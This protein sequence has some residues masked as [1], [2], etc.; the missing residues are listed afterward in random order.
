MIL[1]H[2]LVGPASQGN[3]AGRCTFPGFYQQFLQPTLDGGDAAA[4]AALA[5]LTNWFRVAATLAGAAPGA[6]VTN[7]DPVEPA[8][9]FERGSLNR[10]VTENADR[11]MARLGGG[12]APLIGP[13]FAA[14]IARLTRR[15]QDT[16]DATLAFHRDVNTKTFDDSTDRPWLSAS[17]VC[18]TSRPKPA[19]PRFTTLW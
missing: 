10:W 4:A 12:G 15:M 18:A 19:S 13:L 17:S 8:N 2:Q 14:G 6:P 16:N 5:P 9:P 11:H 3:A 1:P 7:V